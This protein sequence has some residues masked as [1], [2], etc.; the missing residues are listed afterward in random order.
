M[1]QYVD[2][3]LGEN[4]RVVLRGRWPMV[5]WVGAWLALIFLGVIIVGVWI[6]LQST[7]TMLTTEFA[8][9]DQRVVLKRGFI[10]RDTREL[11]VRSVET[12]Q[13]HQSVLG[14]LFNYG[15][16]VVTGTGDSVIVFPPMSDP[17]SFR[18]AIESSRS[19][20]SDGT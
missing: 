8:V 1:A 9:T 13:L 3:S 2:Q 14:R 4:E 17:V 7:I 11:A 12:V 20:A 5:F 18:R 16:L 15:S 10:N 6:F 19:S